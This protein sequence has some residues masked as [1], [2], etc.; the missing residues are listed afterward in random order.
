MNEAGFAV[1]GSKID[2]QSP[3]A[4]D[5]DIRQLFRDVL[6]SSCS[7]F[8]PELQGNNVMVVE[9]SEQR[10]PAIRV[11]NHDDAVGDGQPF[12]FLLKYA[13]YGSTRRPKVLLVPSVDALL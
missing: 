3:S 13:G 2:I 1:E 5:H 11:E 12:D 8:L 9:L 10:V 4:L 7:V 6:D